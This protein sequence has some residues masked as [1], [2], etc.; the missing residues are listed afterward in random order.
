MNKF[1]RC[2]QCKLYK[3]RLKFYN[4]RNNLDKLCFY[5]KKCKSY[6]DKKYRYNINVKHC[7]KLEKKQKYKCKLCYRKQQKT[8]QYTSLCIDHC[9][10]C[11][12]LRG[13]ICHACNRG[14]G[15]LQEN[16]QLL[17]RIIKYLKR[18]KNDCI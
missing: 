15:L 14:I 4:D 12:K 3:H 5:C 7:L 11:S 10:K 17:N 6:I 18:H 9:H 8:G 1:K 2:G 16:I 13:L